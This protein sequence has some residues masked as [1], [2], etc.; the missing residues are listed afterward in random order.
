VS[1]RRAEDAIRHWSD[2]LSDAVTFRERDVR[3]RNADH[4]EAADRV[5]PMSWS[6]GEPLQEKLDL[7]S[8]AIDGVENIS[9]D[10]R[11]SAVVAI[12][13]LAQALGE[14]AIRNA[15]ALEHWP[16]GSV[17]AYKFPWTRR[18]LIRLGWQL[19]VVGGAVGFHRLRDRLVDPEKYEEGRTVLHVAASFARLGFDVAFDEPAQGKTSVAHPDVR[20]RNLPMG[21]E[22]F[23]EVTMLR[24]SQRLKRYTETLGGLTTPP[25]ALAKGGVLHAGR[26]CRWFAKRRIEAYRARLERAAEAALAS[27]AVVEESESDAFEF[28][29]AP[30]SR[31]EELSAWAEERGLGAMFVEGPECDLDESD[32]IAGALRGKEKQLPRDG[33]GVVVIWTNGL[34]LRDRQRMRR[35]ALTL[36]EEVSEAPHVAAVVVAS[37]SLDEHGDPR[38]LRVGRHV[39]ARVRP[40]P[41][42]TER[43]LVVRNEHAS[44]STAREVATATIDAFGRGGGT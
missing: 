29:F 10:E 32:R 15:L 3:G 12:E 2:A 19:S 4:H 24:Q 41:Q 35:L 28:A 21:I 8:I 13:R 23:V 25:F 6:V 9:E 22:S 30:A 18:E 39:F 31:Y 17:L 44:A 36:Q 33:A 37:T 40:Y 7:R 20:I 16:L 27:D 1:R 42:R 5:V 14:H 43:F 11:R 34:E 26:I 38:I